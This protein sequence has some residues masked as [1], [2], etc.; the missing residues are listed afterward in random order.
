MSTVDW[1]VAY[2][3]ALGA[4]PTPAALGF[5]AKWQPWEGGATKNNATYNYFNTTEDAPGATSIN[6]VGVKAY[7]SLAV[8]AK[9]FARTL[10]SNPHYAPLVSFL[11]TGQG[12]PSP[13]LATWVSGSPD[14]QHGLAYA[15]KITGASV[16]TA[17]T[18]TTTPDASLGVAPSAASAAAAG[19]ASIRAQAAAG[20]GQEASGQVT[21]TDAFKSLTSYV[22]QAMTKLPQIHPDTLTAAA[23]DPS[24]L[25][26]Q[27]VSL[28]QKYIGVK[29]T[30]GGT[31]AQTGFDCSGL[32][33][34]V[35]S[36]LGVK[37]PR[38]TYAQWDAGTPVANTDLKPGDEVF[39]TGSDPQGGKPGHEGLYIGDGKFIEAPGTGM[40]VRVSTLA[41]RSDYVGARRFA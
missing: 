4:K 37:I 29:Y 39:F 30:W 6:S 14:S 7:P 28:A 15:A 32:V 38:T 3:N 20:F 10:L 17:P 33:Q 19:A 27:A 11:R 8:G 24:G 12:D 35:W 9:A 13:G 18:G 41:G 26:A 34:H 1:R 40:Q 5:L 31:T 2:L 22:S 36:A 23:A 21:P 25:E 16:P